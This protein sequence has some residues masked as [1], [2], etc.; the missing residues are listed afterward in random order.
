MRKGDWDQKS[1]DRH[2][3]SR[4]PGKKGGGHFFITVLVLAIVVLGGFAAFKFG[5]PQVR[6]AGSTLFEGGI[7]FVVWAID[8]VK[9]LAKRAGGQNPEELGFERLGDSQQ[10]N[11]YAVP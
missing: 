2:R 10:D 3:E 5:P 9:G 7:G 4:G 8:S 11:L 6:D 1:F